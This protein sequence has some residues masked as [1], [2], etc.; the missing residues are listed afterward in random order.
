[1]D[2]WL[3][4]RELGRA[5]GADVLALVA[6]LASAG[7][8]IIQATRKRKDV[9]IEE[10]QQRNEALEIRVSK[11]EGLVDGLRVELVQSERNVFL[12]RRVVAQAGLEDPTLEESA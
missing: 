10:L 5:V 4:I 7:A 2:W 12:L 6:A 11:L 1:M 8:I 3:A 9:D